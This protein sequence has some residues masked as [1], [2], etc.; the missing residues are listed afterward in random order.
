MAKKTA[1]ISFTDKGSLLNK[2]L[3]RRLEKFGYSCACFSSEK[4][5]AKHGINSIE[6]NYVQWMKKIFDEYDYILFVGA[7]GIAIRGIAPYVKDKF[8]DPA[9]VVVDENAKFAIPVL[10]GH[11]GGANEFTKDICIITDSQ[12]VITTATDIN[13]KFAVDVFAKK[14]NLVIMQREMIKVISSALLSDEK[15]CMHCDGIYK[16]GIP[17]GITK[18]SKGKIGFL[19]SVFSNTAQY[20]N[21]LNLVPKKVHI[22]IGCRK[23]TPKEAIQAAVDGFLKENHIFK[24]AVCKV[25][26][27]TIKHNERG[28]IEFCTEKKLPITFFS[29]DNLNKAEG[30]FTPSEFVRSITGTDNV[31]E[32]AA[33]LSSNNGKI[34][35][36]KTKY[37]GVTVAAACEEWSVDFG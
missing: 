33:V 7:V 11:I 37:D 17:D 25:A 23:D 24:E 34:I 8:K 1:V 12:P 31:C 36:E 19:I 26:T 32:R 35:A 3:G 22:G 18:T 14:N 2:K 30:K 5:A 6:G 9:V 10:S 16:N 13:N 29:A 20:D 15:V 21:M 28:L 4:Y 27:I